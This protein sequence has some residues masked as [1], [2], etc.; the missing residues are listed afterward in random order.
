MQM[1]F[2][3]QVRSKAVVGGRRSVSAESQVR[4]QAS[5]CEICSGRTGIGTGTSPRTSVLPCGYN[6][7]SG[8]YV[9]P[10]ACCCYQKG[11]RAKPGNFRTKLC[12]LEYRGAMCR[13]VMVFRYL[14]WTIR[15]YIRNGLAWLWYSLN[16]QCRTWLGD[17]RTDKQ[18]E[19]HVVA[20]RC[21]FFP[22]TG[23]NI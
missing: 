17:I 18:T 23:W 1:K 22:E 4:S 2:I 14:K 6:Y 19:R 7:T 10:S 16:L 5:T 8:L 9:Y 15:F 20:N 21:C 13:G 11:K 3:L 12:S